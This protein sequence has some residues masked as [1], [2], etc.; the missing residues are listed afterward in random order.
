MGR[1]EAL[2][3]QAV[4]ANVRSSANQLKH[5]STLLENLSDNDGLLIVGAEYSLGTGEVEF[6]E[7][8]PAY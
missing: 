6:F 3:E 7:D 4:R 1:C 2:I 8:V 5:G